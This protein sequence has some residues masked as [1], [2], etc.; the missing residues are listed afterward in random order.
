ML[1]DVVVML[2]DVVVMLHDVVVMLHDVVVMLHDI[3]H[4]DDLF[5]IALHYNNNQLLQAPKVMS[6]PVYL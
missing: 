5:H 6:L 4:Q 1:H 3:V 2:H